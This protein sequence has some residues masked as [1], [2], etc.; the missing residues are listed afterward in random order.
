MTSKTHGR[1]RSLGSIALALLV[2]VSAGTAVTFT[3]S[4]AGDTT[5]SLSPTE[6]N[7]ESGETTTY[8]VVVENTD[9]GI[10]STDASV[11]IDDPSVGSITDVSIAGTP[12]NSN[13]VITDNGSTASFDAIYFG[14]ALDDDPDGVTI[15]TVTVEGNA[16]GSTDLSTNVTEIS[17]SNGVVYTVTGTNGATL[18]VDDGTQTTT[19]TTG[20]TTAPS[21]PTATTGTSTTETAT[22]TATSTTTT[23][24]E[25][26]AT[27]GTETATDT[28][29][30]ATDT[31]ETTAGTTTGTTTQTTTATTTTADEDDSTTNGTAGTG[32]G[33][34]TVNEQAVRDA[35]SGSGLSDDQVNGVASALAASELSA[36]ER[37][38]ITDA[39]AGDGLT[40]AERGA[41]A[42]AIADGLSDDELVAL[43]EALDDGVLTNAEREAL[44]FLDLAPDDAAYYQVDLVTGE[45][46]EEL[47]SGEGYY[48]PDELIRFAHGDTDDGITRVSNGEFV[49][50]ESVA[51]RIESEDITVENGTATVTVTVS[52]GAP[53]DLTLA[54]YE[55]IGPGWSPATEAKQTFVDSETRTLASGTHTF[56]VDLPDAENSAA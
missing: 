52:E 13:V 18:Q 43:S 51:D 42:N 14:N 22:Q 34:Q 48:T 11:S 25:T 36:D 19:A 54:S 5:V 55:K 3:A 49:E 30:T 31:T 46:I 9:D 50:N 21:T 33:D 6:R 2:L 12:A 15:A 26:T 45:P 20:T 24:T 23:G 53:V 28:T 17:D 10:G 35:L 44:G 8:A 29:G 37:T 38:T 40:D 27:T 56:T 47:R 32:D 39:L 41:I 16:A 4:A 7:I 1:R